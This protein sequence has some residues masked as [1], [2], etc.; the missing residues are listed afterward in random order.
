MIDWQRIRDLKAEIGSGSFDKIVALFLDEADAT[1]TQ[2]LAATTAPDM[3]RDLHALKGI[4]LNL[5]F[6]E[7]A[8]LCQTFETRAAGGDADLPLDQIQDAYS[9]SRTEFVTNLAAMT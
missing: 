3:K 9:R 7:L 8:G 6:A 5:G 4:A 1:T 2:M